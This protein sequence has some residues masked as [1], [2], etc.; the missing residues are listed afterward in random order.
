MGMKVLIT[1]CQGFIGKNLVIKLNK[2]SDISLTTFNRGMDV[3]LLEGY[4][5]KADYV[6]H[7]AGENRT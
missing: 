5:Q 7:L 4:L 6:I 3:S 2:Y 1:G